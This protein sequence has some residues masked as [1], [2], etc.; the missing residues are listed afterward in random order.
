MSDPGQSVDLILAGGGLAAGLVALRLKRAR[1]GL[2]I[3]IVERAATLGAGHTWSLFESDLPPAILDWVSPL[4]AH[5]WDGY[6]VR[7]PA[8]SRTLETPYATIS[9]ERFDAA[10]RGG[11]GRGAR[12]L[13]GVR[14]RRCCPTAWCWATSGRLSPAPWSTRA[15][16]PGTPRRRA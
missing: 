12:A 2:R 5:R 1:P 13:R 16:R 7:F 4:F 14:S 6:H 3:L 10:V 15:A 11:R 9:A 8:H